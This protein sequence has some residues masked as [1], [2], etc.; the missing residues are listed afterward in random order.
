M[1]S[2]RDAYDVEMYSPPPREI[3]AHIKEQQKQQYLFRNEAIE[4]GRHV[5]YQLC[6]ADNK[7]ICVLDG[8]GNHKRVSANC[9]HGLLTADFDSITVV[10][11]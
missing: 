4:R 6:A 3:P 8:H 11:F 10:T 7:N 9:P 5:G 2:V 1:P